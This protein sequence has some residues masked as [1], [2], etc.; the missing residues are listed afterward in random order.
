M[1]RRA[2]AMQDHGPAP[3]PSLAFL[4]TLFLGGRFDPEAAKPMRAHGVP[5][6]A[7]PRLARLSVALLVAG[8]GFT[9][10]ADAAWAHAIGVVSLLA[11]VAFAFP[12]ALPP[13]S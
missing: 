1:S 4:L 10:V 13:E 7:H 8:V 3:K 9:T 2:P 12:A 6:A 11:F 5:R